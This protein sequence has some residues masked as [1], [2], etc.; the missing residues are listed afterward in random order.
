[1][2]GTEKLGKSIEEAIEK[3]ED[4][5]WEEKLR[6]DVILLWNKIELQFDSNR[7]PKRR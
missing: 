5:G 3:I 1:M 6:Q 4:E 7:K 2:L